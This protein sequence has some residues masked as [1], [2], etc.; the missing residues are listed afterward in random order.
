MGESDNCPVEGVKKAP[1]VVMPLGPNVS[2]QV[3]SEEL[4]PRGQRGSPTRAI[5]FP[6]S[7][8]GAQEK[9]WRKGGSHLRE[10]LG[11]LGVQEGHRHLLRVE[12]ETPPASQRFFSPT[13]QKRPVIGEEDAHL[14]VS[15]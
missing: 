2:W 14:L 8:L 9:F 7:S 3:T 12:R 15:P 11:G 10:T 4:G 5:S 6:G 13:N 1:Q